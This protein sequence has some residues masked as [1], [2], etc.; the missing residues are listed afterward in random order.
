MKKNKKKWMRKMWLQ[1]SKM[2]RI[3]LAIILLF[4]SL[5]LSSCKNDMT[6]LDKYFSDIKSL[7]PKQIDTL[8]TVNSPEL[9]LYEAF[10]LRD[11]FSNDLQVL[12]S[13]N[14]EIDQVL[15]GE[16][17]DLNRRKEILENYPLDGLHMVGTY[18]TS[19]DFWGLIELSLIHI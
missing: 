14:V 10:E 4:L 1:E 7:P 5:F 6:D 8:P 11:P 17:P 9:F 13:Q 2:R 3:K 15:S 16:G 19:N 12:T 18:E